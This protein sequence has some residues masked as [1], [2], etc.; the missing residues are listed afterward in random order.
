MKNKIVYNT[1]NEDTSIQ[2][3]K[4]KESED[5]IIDFYTKV[6]NTSKMKKTVVNNQYKFWRQRRWES[7]HTIEDIID[8]MTPKSKEKNDTSLSYE[9]SVEKKVDYLFIKKERYTICN[10]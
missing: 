4:N 6:L 1:P 2:Y 8:S 10:H 3:N 7:I 9:E 5:N